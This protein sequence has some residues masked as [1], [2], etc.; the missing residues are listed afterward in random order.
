MAK[1]LARL[2]MKSKNTQITKIRNERW[3][4]DQCH[5]NKMNFKRTLW[6]CIATNRIIYKKWLIPRN[7]QPTKI[8]SQT[9][10]LNRSTTSKEKESAIKYLSTNNSPGEM[11]SLKNSLEHLRNYQYKMFSNF[12]T[13]FKMRE[14]V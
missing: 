3:Y 9:E 2:M 6:N 14:Y 8:E 4:Y 10:N 13:K 7:I 12:L 5:R 11:A 1:L